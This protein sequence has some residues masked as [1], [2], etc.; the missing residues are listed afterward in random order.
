MRQVEAGDQDVNEFSLELEP[1][2][3]V[4]GNVTLARG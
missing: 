3:D 1:L 2:R 4:A